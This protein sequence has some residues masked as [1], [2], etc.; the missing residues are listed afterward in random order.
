MIFQGALPYSYRSGIKAAD[1]CG[2]RHQSTG[3]NL[4]RKLKL[5]FQFATQDA[6]RHNPL[7]RPGLLHGD[8]PRSPSAAPG[9]CP[10]RGNLRVRQEFG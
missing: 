9:W 7:L 3:I 1:P 5:Y 8:I 2:N 6:V 4:R 10:D